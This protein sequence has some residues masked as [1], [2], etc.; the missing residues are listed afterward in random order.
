VQTRCRR[1][2]AEVSRGQGFLQTLRFKRPEFREQCNAAITPVGLPNAAAGSPWEAEGKGFRV[3]VRSSPP[4]P[5]RPGR[6][7]GIAVALE[8]MVGC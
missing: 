1:A 8:P 5:F 4:Q 7:K 6:R 3:D 2:C